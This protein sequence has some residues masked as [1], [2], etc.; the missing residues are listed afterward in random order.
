MTTK[1]VAIFSTKVHDQLLRRL[2]AAVADLPAPLTSATPSSAS[3]TTSA[4]TSPT[5][6]CERPPRIQDQR[7]ELENHAGWPRFGWYVFAIGSL[8]GVGGGNAR[9]LARSLMPRSIR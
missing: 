5:R 1:R 3:T 4:A 7:R 6:A 8:P 2:L 9:P